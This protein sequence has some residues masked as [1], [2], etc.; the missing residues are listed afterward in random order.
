VLIMTADGRPANAA[1]MIGLYLY[2]QA[3]VFFNVGYASAIAWVLLMVIMLF[4]AAQFFFAKYW[5]FYE[6]EARR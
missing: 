2:R 3:F 1:L 4:T 5:V 6:G